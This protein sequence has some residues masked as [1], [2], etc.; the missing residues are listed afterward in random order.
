MPFEVRMVH[1]V[2]TASSNFLFGA[3]LVWLLGHRDATHDL[4]LR[5]ASRR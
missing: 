3:L 1:L 4:P 2:E 5:A